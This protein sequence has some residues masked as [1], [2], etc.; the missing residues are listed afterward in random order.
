MKRDNYVTLGSYLV[1]VGDKDGGHVKP[2]L[3]EAGPFA[4]L[5]YD[6]HHHSAMGIIRFDSR[7]Y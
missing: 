1:G 3:V 6:L 4:E 5:L 7:I 2:S